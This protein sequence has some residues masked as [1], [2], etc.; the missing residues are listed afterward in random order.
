MTADWTDDE[1]HE[2]FD[3]MMKA[4]LA[5]DKLIRDLR[6][7][8]F[9]VDPCQRRVVARWLDMFDKGTKVPIRKRLALLRGMLEASPCQ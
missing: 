8:G 7:A 2:V 9:P 3:S 5:L 1:V 6:R 4:E